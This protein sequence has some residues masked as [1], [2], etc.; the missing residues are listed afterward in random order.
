[1]DVDDAGGD[2]GGDSVERKVSTFQTR[3][4]DTITEPAVLL[5]FLLPWTWGIFSWLPQQSAAAAPD[6]G[7]GVAPLRQLLRLTQVRE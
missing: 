2:Y 1:M 3:L 5:G 7:H 6:L 4:K